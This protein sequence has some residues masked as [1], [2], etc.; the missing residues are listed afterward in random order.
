[1]GVSISLS[2]TKAD[3]EEPDIRAVM[4]FKI[5]ES[6]PAPVSCLDFIA[7]PNHFLSSTL[8]LIEETSGDIC[9]TENYVGHKC[10]LKAFQQKLHDRFQ[11]TFFSRGS[12]RMWT[13]TQRGELHDEAVCSQLVTDTQKFRFVARSTVSGATVFDDPS[14]C[15]NL[16]M[17]M[18]PVNMEKSL[19]SSRRRLRSHMIM[20][21]P[22]SVDT[23]KTWSK[24]STLPSEMSGHE[25]TEIVPGVFIGSELAAADIV[26]MRDLGVTH[27]VN[28]NVGST[29]SMF[30]D[31]FKYCSVVLN[32]SV[33]ETFDDAFFEAVKFVGHALEE[34]GAVLIHCRKGK[35]RS[36]ALCTAFLMRYKK[37]RFADALGLVETKRPI[38]HVNQ[39]FLAQ[40]RSLSPSCKV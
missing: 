11:V 38:V 16:F 14:W 30:P 35:S 37:M 26:S 32:D 18:N 15:S 4:L 2:Q 6:G 36:A 8:L 12:R 31:E 7:E 23:A 27:I 20:G 1:M 19:F 39:G 21:A 3:P 29:P 10:S 22:L 13:I 9:E 40:L 5:D 25:Y 17:L 33:F 24:T 34:G 28:M